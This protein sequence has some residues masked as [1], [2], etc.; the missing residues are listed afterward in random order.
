MRVIGQYLMRVASVLRARGFDA[1]LAGLSR[2]S[3]K[4]KGSNQNGFP[5]LSLNCVHLD[6]EASLDVIVRT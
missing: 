4:S 2:R 3:L 5:S 1:F 6:H